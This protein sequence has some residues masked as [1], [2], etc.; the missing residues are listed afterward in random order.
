MSR[1]RLAVAV[2]GT[3]T[4]L[5]IGAAVVRA[6][7]L[8]ALVVP[9]VSSVGVLW[10]VLRWTA[11]DG[12]GDAEVAR[13]T[14]ASYALHLVLS[15]LIGSSGLTV[16]FFGG[17]AD[18]YHIDSVALARHWAEGTL[19]PDLAAGK[20]GFYYALA[21]LYEVLGPYRVG[22]LALIA[23]FSALLVPLS[24]DTTRRLFG[25]RARHA[26][27]PLI[28]LLPGFL[29]WT[30]QLLREAP[31]MAGLALG[32]NLA[33]RISEEFRPSRLAVLAA[34]VAVLFTLRANVAYV[35]GAGLLVGLALGGRHLI[36]GVATAAATLGF[37]A[38]LVLGGGLG[39]SGYQRSATADLQQVNTVR[40]ALA[41]TANSG[42]GEEADVSTAQG[43]IAYLPIGLPQL[44]LGPFPWQIGNFRQAL[45]LL[46][47]MTVWWL[48]PAFVRGMRSGCRA[49][50]RRATLLLGPA[51]GIALVLTLLIG[52]VGTLVRERIQVTVLLL[53]F[54]ALGWARERELGSFRSGPGDSAVDRLTSRSVA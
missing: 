18:G 50:G 41:T 34:T 15:L 48:V 46:E 9:A 23:L 26:I 37:V 31:I 13:W 7:Y 19:M 38:V 52:N 33:V 1:E 14:Y 11:V 12:T 2:G 40:S 51:A 20:E 5:A 6:P 17:D 39:E 44:L 22:G 24:A 47:A 45:G 4:A 43:S 32:A 8:Y 53:P 30:S 10:A 27:L 21:R 35:F 16:T 36:A 29:L 28:V 25:E 54:V 49:I 3:A 42:I